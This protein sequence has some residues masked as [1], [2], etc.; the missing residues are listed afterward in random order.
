MKSSMG[1]II[2][3]LLSVLVVLMDGRSHH[4]FAFER[5]S[6]SRKTVLRYLRGYTEA[7]LVVEYRGSEGRL[8]R[9]VKPPGFRPMYA[10]KK[11]I[12]CQQIKDIDDFHYSRNMPDQRKYYCKVCARA[13]E[14]QWRQLNRGKLIPYW[15]R[16]YQKHRTKKREHAREYARKK[17]A[18]QKALRE[19]QPA[20]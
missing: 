19:N 18:E 5:L 8:W 11:C 14:K 13:Y 4:I 20:L 16:Q 12:A 6:L 7:G 15:R 2:D 17:R 1:S 3:G 10:R 9:L